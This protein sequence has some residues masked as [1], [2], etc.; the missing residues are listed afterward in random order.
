MPDSSATSFTVKPACFLLWIRVQAQRPL[1][2]HFLLK[3]LHFWLVRPEQAPYALPKDMQDINR[4]D[5]QHYLLRCAL[6]GNYLAP[7]VTSQ[8]H[9]VLDVGCG[10]GHWGMEMA[11]AF[12]HAQMIGLDLE[13]ADRERAEV[14][15]N[16]Q[17][18]QGDLLQGLPFAEQTFDF[19]HQRL[20]VMGIP[21][22]RWVAVIAELLRATRSGG[23][24][25][26]IESGTTFL[27]AG[28]LTQ[29]WCEWGC[30]SAWLVASIPARFPT[31]RSLLVRPGCRRS[32]A[33][34]LRFPL[35]IG[36]EHCRAGRR[37][38]A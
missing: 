13:R 23:W 30:R 38:W 14:P 37:V 33:A 10:T 32:G 4:L 15:A 31:W 27:P 7:L 17:F 3:C 28:E 36:R 24:I 18:Q 8:I 11:L 21:T 25:E 26:L 6:K 12:P 34:P 20:L 2:I 19:V 5:F 9:N 16:Y 1:S 22:Q 35:A 29:R